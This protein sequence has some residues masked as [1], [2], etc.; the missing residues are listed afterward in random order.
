ML[1]VQAS[2]LSVAETPAQIWAASR[3]TR[4]PETHRVSAAAQSACHSGEYMSAGPTGR[5][6]LTR[7]TGKHL[8]DALEHN[9]TRGDILSY[10]LQMI[11][12]MPRVSIVLGQYRA[13]RV[14]CNVCVYI[15]PTRLHKASSTMLD[16]EQG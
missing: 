16:T 10:N 6:N 5:A 12:L 7:S 13:L 1:E 4:T 11:T 8:H 2:L 3:Q 9:A 15:D 14:S